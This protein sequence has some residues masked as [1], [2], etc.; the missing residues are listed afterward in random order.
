MEE[1]AETRPMPSGRGSD[2]RERLV[3]AAY[4][5]F[6]RD[7]VKAVGIEAILERSGVARQTLYRHFA[8]KQG[9]ALAFLDR[10]EELWTKGW[11]QA[12]V[13]RRASAPRDRLLAIFAVFDE[14]F[15]TPHF[16][17]CSFI[18]VM[19]EHPDGAHALNR[20]ATA[21]LAGIREFLVA[22]A[23]AAGS[24]DPDG[25]AREWHILMK[26]SIVAAGEGDRD[27]AQRAQRIGALLL[28]HDERHR[29]PEIG[30]GR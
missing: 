23:S 26:G 14:W 21:Q 9:L 19:L 16:E 2:A 30:V 13:Q 22:L 18:N 20:A 4:E 8:S 27:A 1:L 12:E 28:A 29:D 6:A 15:R 17:G 25:L 7:G 10:R 11:L 3:T 5:L 24:S